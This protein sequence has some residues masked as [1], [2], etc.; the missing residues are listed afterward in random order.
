MASPLIGSL[1]SC[2][3]LSKG[4]PDSSLALMVNLKRAEL[5]FG[6]PL[7]VPATPVKFTLRNFK[8]DEYSSFNFRTSTG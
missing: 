2:R 8:V 1:A 5:E 3:L 7:R 4:T 6:V